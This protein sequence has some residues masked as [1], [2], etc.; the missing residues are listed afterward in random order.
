MPLE[1]LPRYLRT[2]DTICVHSF[3]KRCPRTQVKLGQPGAQ[4]LSRLK[5]SLGLAL[6]LSLS[7]TASLL[8]ARTGARWLM[9]IQKK[10]FASD[11]AVDGSD[12]RS[13]KFRIS[14]PNLW[15]Q[16]FALVQTVKDHMLNWPLVPLGKPV[17]EGLPV[18]CCMDCQSGEVGAKHQHE[19]GTTI[20]N[21]MK[22]HHHN[23]HQH[24]LHHQHH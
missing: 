4:L 21:N 10:T 24:H 15:N 19:R 7:W 3:A 18:T 14:K 16:N 9:Q 22:S 5:T 23:H 20:S 13:L 17:E 2:V 12:T 6:S 11:S 8:F 1:C